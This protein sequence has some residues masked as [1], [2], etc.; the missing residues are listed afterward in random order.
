VHYLP[1]AD[2]IQRDSQLERTIDVFNATAR[3]NC[4]AICLGM[5]TSSAALRKKL[6]ISGSCVMSTFAALDE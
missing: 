6:L 4:L 2:A 5:N 3:T 1:D